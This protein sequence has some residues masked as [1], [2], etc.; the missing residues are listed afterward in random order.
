[1][2]SPVAPKATLTP[3]ELEPGL[4]G[5]VCPETGGV[6]ID[7]ESYRAWIARPDAG[8]PSE[9]AVEPIAEDTERVLISPRTGRIMVKCLVDLGV[10]FRIDSD[11]HSGGF[12]LDRGELERLKAAG[13]HRR[14]HH[15][16]SEA[17]QRKLRELE[18]DQRRLERLAEM[19]GPEDLDRVRGVADWVR[20]HPHRDVV[21][22]W[23]LGTLDAD[24]A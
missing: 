12:W 4:K 14:L 23:I 9:P 24:R 15:V 21:L 18:T 11:T 3:T 8:D 16:V 7:G 5:W 10:P 2:Q 17:W 6:W 19:L 20:D 22:A 1:M 13:L